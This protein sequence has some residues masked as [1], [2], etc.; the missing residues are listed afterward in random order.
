MQE[1]GRDDIITKE[2]KEEKRLRP[3]GESYGGKVKAGKYGEKL[4]G[5]KRTVGGNEKR[6]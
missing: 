1:V 6:G 4:K 3:K 5:E 2:K